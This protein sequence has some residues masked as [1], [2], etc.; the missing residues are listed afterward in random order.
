MMTVLFS[1]A[2]YSA[3]G[4]SVKKRAAVA[5]VKV[6]PVEPLSGVAPGKRANLD[7]AL[8]MLRQPRP[9]PGG[10]AKAVSAGAGLRLAD[11]GQPRKSTEKRDSRSQVQGVMERKRRQG[12]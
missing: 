6:R 3:D 7:A 10:S 2:A 5:Q 4:V 1:L 11:K 9:V 12:S 8:K